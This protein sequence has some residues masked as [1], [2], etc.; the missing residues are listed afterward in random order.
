MSDKDL[1]Q[2]INKVHTFAE[3]VNQS[4]I[5]SKKT[6]IL[7]NHTMPNKCINIL[8]YLKIHD[9]LIDL[10]YQTLPGSHF[11]ICA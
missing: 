2:P 5:G 8:K 3:N 4:I 10:S 9:W 11:S 7:Q 6:A 1:R